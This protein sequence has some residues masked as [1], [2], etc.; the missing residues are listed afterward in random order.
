[1]F[2]CRR[3]TD[4]R[5]HTKY[6]SSS[7][8]SRY[9]WFRC[10]TPGWTHCSLLLLAATDLPIMSWEA[11]AR[12]GGAMTAET[13]CSSF[14]SK[15]LSL[16]HLFYFM[17]ITQR[18]FKRGVWYSA[19]NWDPAESEVKQAYRLDTW[20]GKRSLGWGKVTNRSKVSEMYK[21]QRKVRKKLTHL[22]KAVT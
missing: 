3:H 4:T 22:H 9:W 19:R 11:A 5:K 17:L 2:K 18:G 12:L 15:S 14:S 13:Q 8:S 7:P 21:R 10:V 6:T 20:T 16:D 1:M